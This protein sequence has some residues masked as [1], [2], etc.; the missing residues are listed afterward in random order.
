MKPKEKNLGHSVLY[1]HCLKKWGGRF[2][3][4]PRLIA[5]IIV[6]IFVSCYQPSVG[7]R[8]LAIMTQHV[9]MHGK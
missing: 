3:R 6:H 5:P 4:V 8:L 1:F 9:A 2:P 7:D